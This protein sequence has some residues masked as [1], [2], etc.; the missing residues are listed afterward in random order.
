MLFFVEKC[1]FDKNRNLKFTYSRI[2]FSYQIF[3]RL[4]TKWF[5]GVAKTCGRVATKDDYSY[6]YLSIDY[7]TYFFVCGFISF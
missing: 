6:T 2:N 7:K 5:Q 1:N 3:M 4:G